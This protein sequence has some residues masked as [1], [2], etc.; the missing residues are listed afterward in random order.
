M[1]SHDEKQLAVE[2]PQWLIQVYHNQLLLQWFDRDEVRSMLPTD[3]VCK[4]AGI[5][6]APYVDGRAGD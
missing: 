2:P 1:T 5:N 4:P 6:V 3:P